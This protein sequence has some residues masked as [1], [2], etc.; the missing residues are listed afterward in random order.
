MNPL[1]PRSLNSLLSLTLLLASLSAAPGC[2]KQALYDAALSDVS[3]RD[4]QITDQL[5]RMTRSAEQLS[6]L[7][8]EKDHLVAEIAS[9]RG[10][11]VTGF[12]KGCRPLSR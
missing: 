11:L 12:R 10:A 9:L 6:V 1:H 2:V 7:S 5:E 8:Q 3:D 4:A